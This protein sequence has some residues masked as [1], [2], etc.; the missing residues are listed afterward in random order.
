M[1][2][3]PTKLQLWLL[4]AGIAITLGVLCDAIGGCGSLRCSPA[5]PGEPT[6]ADCIAY[7]GD[8]AVKFWRNDKE[9][10]GCTPYCACAGDA[11]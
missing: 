7:C 3:E 6:V 4:G 5:K 2:T 10:P 11:K 1:R 9:W 8:A